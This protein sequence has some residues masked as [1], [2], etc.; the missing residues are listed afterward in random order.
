[1]KTCCIASVEEAELAISYGVDALGLVAAMP[2]GPGV[3][4]D[5]KI[6]E[7]AGMVPPCVDSFLLTSRVKGEDIV[8]HVKNCGPNTVQIVQHID[9][10]EYPVIIKAIPHVR[11]IQVIHVED[12]S[13]LDLIEIYQPYIDAFLLDSGKPNAAIAE[14]GGTGQTHDWSISAEFVKR[15]NKPV[16]ITLGI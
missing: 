5:D 3:I 9:V 16:F 10:S 6:T 8:H 2:S 1:M 11:R 14:L 13:A 15:S 4:D 12:E 7:I